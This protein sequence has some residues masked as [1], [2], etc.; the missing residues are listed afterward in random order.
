M[1]KPQSVQDERDARRPLRGSISSRRSSRT[2]PP[3][4]ARSATRSA[5]ADVAAVLLR[6]KP[7]GER[8]LINRIKVLAPLVQEKDTALLLDGQ[9][10]TRRARRRRWR[11]PDRDRR[12]HGGGRQPE[13]G[14]DRRL[15]RLEQPRRCDARRRTR[16]GLRDVRRAQRRARRPPFDAD[17]RTDRMVVGAVHGALRRIC[18]EPSRKSPRCRPPAPISSRSATPSGTTHAARSLRLP[19]RHACSRRSRCDE[20]QGTGI[21]AAIIGAAAARRLPRRNPVAAP[22]PDLAYGEYQRGRYVG[23]FKEAMRR[24]EEKNDPKSMTLLGELYADGLGVPNDDKKAAEWY[25]LAAARGDREA[26]FALSM[27]KMTGRGGP[28]D[29]PEAVRLLTEAAKLGHVVARLR[30]RAALS[31]RPADSA[32]FQPR[33]RID[34]PGRPMPAIRRRNTRWPRSTRTAA[35]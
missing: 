9:C 33:R 26:M 14:A 8:D 35:A 28:A 11:A 29:R 32:G 23:A 21:L 22:E 20:W 30:P 13:T 12:V 7:A 25:K 6:L 17:R 2:R 31:R 5:A 24:V 15:W 3:L 4:S 18:R 10:R 1:A 34:A 19:R 27:F 16:R